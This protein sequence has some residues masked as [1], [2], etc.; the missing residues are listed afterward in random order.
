MNNYSW[1][2]QALHKFALSSQFIREASFE[3]EKLLIK[4]QQK[5]D[6]HVFI[7]GLARS[8]STII[9]RALFESK[10]FSSLLYKDMPFVL[11]PNFWSTLSSSSTDI[12]K[13]ERSHGDGIMVSLESPEAFEE[14]FW[15]TFSDKKN[16]SNEKFKTYT[17][18]I[19]H[20]YQKNRYLSK[21]N[22]NIKRIKLINKIFPKSRIFI[23][24]RNPI[25]QA[26][27]LLVQH[28]RFIE[29]S[30]KDKFVSDYMGLI[31]HTEFGPK[32]IPQFKNN[33]K[34]ENDFEINHWI[35]QWILIYKNCLTDFEDN[36]SVE[37][38]CYEELCRSKNYW[39]KILETL[40]V[41]Y[42]DFDF[43][44]S[45]AQILLDL[46]EDITEQALNLYSK[47]F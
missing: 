10:K 16:D 6:N 31:G 39:S 7:S 47:I 12:I 5:T 24:F 2:Q 37:F 34:F 3:V 11:A 8:G 44:E 26:N 18:L 42:Y 36:N 46:D 23:P 33:I 30:K 14:V 40:G 45:K 41:S 20:K 43:K 13:T 21:N 28:K 35:E 29:A 1:L 9:L 17:N 22:Q 32:Y 15:K 27:S 38:I 25:Q 4:P 19:N